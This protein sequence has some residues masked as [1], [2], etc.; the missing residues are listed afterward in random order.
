M[1]VLFIVVANQ[2]LQCLGARYCDVF[3]SV[4]FI[5]LWEIGSVETMF[6]GVVGGV[7]LKVYRRVSDK[8]TRQDRDDAKL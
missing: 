4:D 2:V 3:N 6:E 7:A 5:R 8:I 1:I